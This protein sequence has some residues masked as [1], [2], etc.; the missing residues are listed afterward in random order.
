M[1]L[2]TFLQQAGIPLLAF[3]VCVYYGIK[4]LLV[5]DVNAIRSKDKPPLKDAKGYCVAS[6]K[7][8]LFFA[9]ITL[10]MSIL[11]FAS[12]VAAF[13]EIC[14]GTIIMGILWKRMNDKYNA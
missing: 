3:V 11:V 2:E 10:I 5:Q 8:M 9:G 13:I 12:V 14:V 1:T 6:G 4:L 7:L